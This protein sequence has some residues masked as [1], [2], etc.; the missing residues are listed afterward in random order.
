MKY[1]HWPKINISETKWGYSAQL[2][3]AYY[4]FNF[5]WLFYRDRNKVHL[6]K[7]TIVWWHVPNITRASNTI[8]QALVDGL[9]KNGSKPTRSNEFTQRLLLFRVVVRSVLMSNFMPTHNNGFQ[10]PQSYKEWVAGKTKMCVSG[11][12]AEPCKKWSFNKNFYFAPKPETHIFVFPAT[13]SLYDC[14]TRNPL[15]CVGMKLLI[16]TNP[17]HYVGNL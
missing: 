4:S 17:T 10:V 5:S 3:Y 15:S 14:R 11:F 16:I 12:W 6:V 8:L 1:Q 13:P 2:K 9:L 7:Q